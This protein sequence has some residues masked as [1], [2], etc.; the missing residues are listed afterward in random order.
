MEQFTEPPLVESPQE[1]LDSPM[2]DAPPIEP[3][4]VT[5]YEPDAPGGNMHTLSPEESPV[6]PWQEYLTEPNS[7][8]SRK[9]SLSPTSPSSV[10]IQ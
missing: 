1:D 7:P 4:P 2:E 8:V 3:E 10:P 6:A 9:H 5:Y